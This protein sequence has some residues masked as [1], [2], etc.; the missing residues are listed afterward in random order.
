MFRIGENDPRRTEFDVGPFKEYHTD[1]IHHINGETVDR[2]TNLLRLKG[3][4]L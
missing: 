2:N 1:H 4:R 3:S